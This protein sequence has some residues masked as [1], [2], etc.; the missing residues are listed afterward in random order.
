MEKYGKYDA[1]S[2]GTDYFCGAMVC[3][4]LCAIKVKERKLIVSFAETM[5]VFFWRDAD[6]GR[7]SHCIDIFVPGEES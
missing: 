1:S 4:T 5:S 3:E 6:N 7:H 2:V